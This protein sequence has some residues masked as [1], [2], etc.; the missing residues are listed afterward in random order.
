[1]FVFAALSVLLLADV[2]PGPELLAKAARSGNVKAAEDLLDAGVNP[3]V[4]DQYGSTALYHAASMNQLDA[5][6]LLLKYHAD[7]NLSGGPN[8]HKSTPLQRAVDLGNVR[9][10]S[11]LL[12][13]GADVNAKGPEGRTALFFAGGHRLDLM[14]MLIEKGADVNAR[15]TEGDSPLD[16]AVWIGALDATAI[17]L[18]HGARLDQVQSTSGATPINEAAYR[19]HAN[20]L[21]YLLQFHPDLRSPDKRG[22][23]PLDNAIRM[24]KEDCAL[25]LIGALPAGSFEKPFEAAIRKKEA[26]V[27]GALLKRGVPVNDALPSGVTPL[28]VAASTGS[29]E[30]VR[31][32]LTSGANPKV[33]GPL[34]DAS[35]KGFPEVVEIL[36]DHGAL[37]N[38]LNAPSGSTALYAAA[39]FGKGETV[40][41]LLKHGADASLCGKAGKSPYQAALE[42]GFKQVAEEI[43]AHGNYSC[44]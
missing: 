42:N 40:R 35:L 1:M 30:V 27:T 7:P 26:V 9:M 6:T 21:R 37:V 39:S 15:D 5:V 31:M 29:L 38:Q 16:E 34:E 19:G 10:A 23:G 2:N 28:A 18:A 14:Q 13:A 43:R 33:G 36:L 4:P 32:L 3:N 20:V 12:A 44:R 41:T 25:L 24:G 17:L 8:P 11:V 22:Y